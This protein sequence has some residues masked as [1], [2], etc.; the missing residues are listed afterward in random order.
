MK[1][2][3]NVISELLPL[4]AEQIVSRDSELM[5]EEHLKACETCRKYLG[6]LKA[7]DSYVGQT[8]ELPMKKLKSILIRKKY[9]LPP[10][11]FLSAS[12]RHCHKTT[13]SGAFRRLCCAYASGMHRFAGCIPKT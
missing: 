7:P 3:C 10:F 6:E 5:V 11:P 8:E 13:K 1:V 4:Y 12:L 2:S 9:R